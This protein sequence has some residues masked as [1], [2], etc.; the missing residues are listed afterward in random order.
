MADEALHFPAEQAAR[1]EPYLP[2]A[3]DDRLIRPWVLLTYA[4]S[5]DGEI[6]AAP[7]VRTTLSGMESKAMTHYLR[8]RHD[9][10]CVGVGTAEAD[11]PGLT[12][13]CLRPRPAARPSRD[14]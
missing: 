3:D 9:A 12:V 10:I 13:G 11:D 1:L 8:T 14:R 7:G 6:A 5:L 2:E 4:A